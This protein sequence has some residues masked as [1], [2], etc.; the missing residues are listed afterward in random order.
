MHHHGVDGGEILAASAAVKN[1]AVSKPA[2]STP[3]GRTVP[4]TVLV[5]VPDGVVSVIRSPVPTP[6]PA[7]SVTT[8]SPAAAGALPEV[9]R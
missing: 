9:S 1:T 7:P 3:A 4:T 5:P 2:V 6:E 8:T